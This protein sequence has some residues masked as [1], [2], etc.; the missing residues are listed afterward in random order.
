M[1]DTIKGKIRRFG[2]SCVGHDIIVGVVRKMKSADETFNSAKQIK[3]TKLYFY[4]VY[5]SKHTPNFGNM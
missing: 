5:G 1:R 3:K 4:T 2:Y